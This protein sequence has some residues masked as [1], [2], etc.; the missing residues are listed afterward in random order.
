MK[1][2]ILS[3]FL[4]LVLM[5]TL[6][7]SFASCKDK[8]EDPTK[9]SFAASLNYEYLRTLN[10]KPVTII[11]YMATSSP[12]DGSYMYLMN[13]PFQSC[14][15]CV[16]NT[17]QLSNT[18]AVY[19]QKGK[20]F[21][22]TDQAIKITGILEVSSS[23]HQFFTDDYGYEF[24]FKIVDAFYEIPT[25]E[26]LGDK[27]LWNAVINSGIIYDI[28]GNSS[29]TML[30]YVHFST[31]WY[32]YTM[33]FQE[34]KDYLYPKDAYD[35]ITVDGA[36]Y[37]YGYKD[38]YFDSLRARVLAINPT[39]LQGLID[40]I[41]KAEALSNDAVN[42]LDAGIKAEGSVFQRVPEFSGT[43]N[44]GRY[45]YQYISSDLQARYDSLYSDFINWMA[46]Y[47]S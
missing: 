3:V 30:D 5:V 9:I 21:E 10:G 39:E 36:Q 6:V 2:R 24:N 38:D 26:E 37:N 4:A 8:Y 46:L 43:F 44:D 29:G 13:L 23:K 40:I 7:F 31:Y 12:V 35:F 14:P 45:Q 32:E 11:G 42:A 20:P 25:A 41:N 17:N 34:G 27:S 1:K 15:F 16:P 28:F 22:Y 19:S 33:Q 47:E 18:M